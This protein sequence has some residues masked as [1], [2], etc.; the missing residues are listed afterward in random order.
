MSPPSGA[1]ELSSCYSSSDSLSDGDRR[2]HQEEEEEDDYA[3]SD[4]NCRRCLE[5]KEEDNYADDAGSQVTFD[6]SSMAGT[7]VAKEALKRGSKLLD[8]ALRK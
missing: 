3:V 7:Y 4:D 6:T 1:D 2:R 5:E 8:D